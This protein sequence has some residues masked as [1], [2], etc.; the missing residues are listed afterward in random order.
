M[1]EKTKRAIAVTVIGGFGWASVVQGLECG[2]GDM[3]AVENPEVWHTHERQPAPPRIPERM[4]IT[5][6]STAR[7]LPSLASSG[8]PGGSFTITIPRL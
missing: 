4:E 6:S 8:T 5:A 1:D 2:R 7:T 3:C